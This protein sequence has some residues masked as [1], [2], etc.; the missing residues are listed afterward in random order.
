MS[1]ALKLA[2][3]WP[4]ISPLLDEALELNGDERAA[5]LANLPSEHHRLRT[6]LQR[7]LAAQ[8]TSFEDDCD[9]SIEPVP[10]DEIGPWRLLQKIGEGGM[11]KVW[12]A[13]RAD[14][15]LG[16][17]V[18]VKLPRNGWQHSLFCRR[19]A[20]ERTFLDALNHPNIA[21][22]MDAGVTASG[23]P[24]LALEYVE[25][26]RI[27]EYCR[28]RELSIAARLELFKKVTRAIAHAHRALVLH[29]DLKPANILITT[30]GDVRVLD[31]GIAKLLEQGQAA[32]TDLTLFA[33]RALT[34]DYASPEQITG[35]PLTVAS[36]VY[37][38]GVVLYELLTGT[39]PYR[40]KRKSPAALEEQIL[41]A[42]PVPPSEIVSDKELRRTLRGSLDRIVLKALRKSPED[43]YLTAD[44]FADDV[45]RYQQKR[46]V[47]ACP[48]SARYRMAMLMRRHRLGFIA[49]SLLLVIL[50]AASG[51]IAHQVH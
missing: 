27:D 15:L 10:G 49:G 23:Q 14:G 24:Y 50:I 31:F 11:A 44:T 32:E 2:A 12:I 26:T 1:L 34:L 19:L 13:E 21:R 36:D 28:H 16:R 47:I 25:G 3:D 46:P 43:R 35:Q 7:L 4:A 20:R 17:P 37:S 41:E 30:D 6:H 22:L 45:E 40:P 18:A 48:D 39:R 33:G 51:V 42:E 29:R 5:W 9:G 8:S 38:L